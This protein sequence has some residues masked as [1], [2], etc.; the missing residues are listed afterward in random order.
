M[1]REQSSNAKCCNTGYKPFNTELNF[2]FLQKIIVSYL[3]ITI[4]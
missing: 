4:K 1:W 2:A 3:F